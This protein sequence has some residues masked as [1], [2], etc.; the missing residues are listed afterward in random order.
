MSEWQ[1]RDPNFAQRIR[2]SFARQAI[3][4]TIGAELGRIE[5]GAVDIEL[6]YH[7]R[8]TQQHG[9]LHAGTVSTVL[10]SACGYAALSLTERGAAVLAVEFKVNFLAP[11]RGERVIARARVKKAG[12]NLSICVADAVALENGSEQTVATMLSTIMTVTGRDLAD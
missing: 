2:D 5:P 12:R 10:D 8:L 4:A 7:E 1:A 6:P 9:Y 3:M 11:A